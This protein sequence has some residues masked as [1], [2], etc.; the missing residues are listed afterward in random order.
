[1]RT[2]SLIAG[3]G[4][5]LAGCASAGPDAGLGRAPGSA[6]ERGLHFAQRAC[7][8]CH[9]L[10]AGQSPNGGAPTFAILQIRFTPIALERRLAE[11]SAHGHYEMPPVFISRDEAKDIAAYI[12]SIGGR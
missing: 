10:D 7:A 3:L 11:I 6:A 5:L 1:M 9:A 8:G 12:G 4:V 2:L